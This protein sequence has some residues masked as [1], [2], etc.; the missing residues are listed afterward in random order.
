MLCQGTRRRTIGPQRK[1]HCQPKRES[2]SVDL[3]MHLHEL[4][5]ELVCNAAARPN[6]ACKTVAAY[7]FEKGEIVALSESLGCA[8]NAKAR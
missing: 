3:R 7:K 4:W 8:Q 1:E 6:A 5:S 2:Q